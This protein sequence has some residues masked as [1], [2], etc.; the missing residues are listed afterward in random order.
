MKFLV[1]MLSDFLC[2]EGLIVT[3]NT[4]FFGSDLLDQIDP[5]DPLILLGKVIPWHEFSVGLL[6]TMGRP[7]IPGSS[8]RRA[9]APKPTE[10]LSDEQVVLQWKRNPYY[11][12]FCGSKAFELVHFRKRV[13]VE[14][15]VKIFQ[16]SVKL[17]GKSIE[18][19]TVNVDTTVQKKIHYLSDGWEVGHKD[20]QPFE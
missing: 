9:V 8:F 2:S 3:K 1:E 11:Q 6:Q 14:G 7:S 13:G 17:H 16:M 19:P 15:V 5:S 20:C 12:A 4:S 18:D 10:N